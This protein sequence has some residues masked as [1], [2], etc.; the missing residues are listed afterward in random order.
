MKKRI[1]MGTIVCAM[2][3][4]LGSGGC[5]PEKDHQ[6]KDNDLCVPE[7]SCVPNAA[8][9]EKWCTRLTSPLSALKTSDWKDAVI[10]NKYEVDYEASGGFPPYT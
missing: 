7:A 5:G 10:G 8:T 2:L 1:E 6:C 4:L 9:G 3:L